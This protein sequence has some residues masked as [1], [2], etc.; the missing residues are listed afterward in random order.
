MR[1]LIVAIFCLCLILTG[2]VDKKEE[3][4][5][6]IEKGSIMDEDGNHV[7]TS[8]RREHAS[9]QIGENEQ[10][11]KGVN[12]DELGPFQT[13]LSLDEM[14]YD[15]KYRNIVTLFIKNL[16]AWAAKDEKAFRECFVS[17]DWADN[18]MFLLEDSAQYEF[19]GAPYIIDQSSE[20]GRINIVFNY[21]TGEQ[22][23]EVKGHTTTFI[24][25]KDGVWKIT[26]ID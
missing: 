3:G 18:H 24:R 21:R 5:V 8:D 1:V 13:G 22:V 2:C 6:A 16:A 23:D 11:L 12:G 9:E 17:K 25:D 10:V 4:Q 14:K 15:E 7:K 19:V 20:N 26:L